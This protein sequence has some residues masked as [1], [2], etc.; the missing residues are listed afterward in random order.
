LVDDAN[1]M[2]MVDRP[3]ILEKLLADFLQ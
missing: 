1:H 2:V 3:E